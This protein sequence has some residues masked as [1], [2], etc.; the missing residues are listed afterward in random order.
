M[1]QLGHLMN[2]VIFIISLY[3]TNNPKAFDQSVESGNSGVAVSLLHFIKHF[4][5]FLDFARLRQSIDHSIEEDRIGL[6]AIGFHFGDK[7]SDRFVT[8]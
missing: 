6:H 1:N 5:G 2:Q 3:I 4:E 7:F 8:F